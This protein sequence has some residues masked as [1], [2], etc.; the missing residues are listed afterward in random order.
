[1]SVTKTRDVSGLPNVRYAEKFSLLNRIFM[2]NS[3]NTTQPEQTNPINKDDNY[4]WGASLAEAGPTFK[5]KY[6]FEK[7][8]L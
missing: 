1:M 5:Y 7:N 6:I 8:Q 4:N 2:R 3:E